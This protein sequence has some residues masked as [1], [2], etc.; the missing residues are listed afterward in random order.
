MSN[1]FGAMLGQLQGYKETGKQRAPRS[2]V[3]ESALKIVQSMEVGDERKIPA[4]KQTVTD[5]R[6]RTGKA[7]ISFDYDGLKGECW[8]RRLPDGTTIK[9][10]IK[11]SQFRLPGEKK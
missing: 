8:V 5:L 4:T 2:K 1:P 9:R 11:V 6:A 3:L 7:F 10:G